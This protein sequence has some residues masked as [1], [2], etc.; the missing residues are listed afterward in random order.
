MR[1]L[2][3][4]MWAQGHLAR[5]STLLAA[6][7]SRQQLETAVSGGVLFRP[8]RGWY[9]TSLADVDQLRAVAAG[10]RVGC[11][12]A[13]RRW[14]VWS[15][16]DDSLHVWMPPTS[17]GVEV[18][19]WPVRDSSEPLPHPSVPHALGVAV[20]ACSHA[21]P[22]VHWSRSAAQR[23]WLDWIVSPSQAIDQAVRCQSD[24]HAL[25]CVD[26]AVHEGAVSASEWASIS[27]TLPRRLRWLHSHTDSRA[28]SGNETIVRHRFR[29]L[30]WRCAPQAH[31]SGIGYIDLLVEGLVPVEVD[32]EAHH[33]SATQRRKDRT[34][35]LVSAALGAPTIRIG[36]EHLD[37]TNWPLVVAAVE[38]QL[39]DAR[40]RRRGPL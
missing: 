28:D 37:A 34:R 22:V 9:A 1:T 31:I 24:E 16:A 8:I 2:T 21:A 5:R 19:P 39:A 14:G 30:G 7:F 17:S 3:E 12:S 10:A 33:S 23:H 15:G 27:S 4:E 32:S 38:R 18:F 35:S 20:R 26:S 36:S 29:L 13:L 11:V 25:A 6:G 40:L